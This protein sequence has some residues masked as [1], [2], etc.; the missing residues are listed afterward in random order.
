MM[1]DKYIYLVTPDYML[2]VIEESKGYS[3]SIKAYSNASMAY[4]NLA[5]T[6]QS[7]I[8][9]YLLVYEELPED[10]TDLVILIN[11]INLVGDKDTVVLLAVNDPSGLE[12]T[13][14]PNI[15]TDNIKFMYLKEYEVMTDAVIRRNLFGTI[16]INKFSPYI[17][18]N[19]VPNFVTTFNSN[20]SLVPVLPKDILLILE[21]VQILDT[22]EY[23][24]KHDNVLKNYSD[25][26]LVSYLRLNR[27]Y[28]LFG[29]DVDYEG[30]VS[31]VN[32]SHNI[33]KVLYRVVCGIIRDEIKVE[34]FCEFEDKEVIGV[35]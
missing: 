11:F 26:S 22:V 3:F 6:N 24:I 12:D 34:E 21:P 27:I 7:S 19:E 31:R 20:K 25:N 33:D 15:N 5:Y 1:R 32:S 23:T 29:L 35:G 10:L 17:E 18:N 2:A 14:I 30:M 16:V 8:L 28:A 9:G 4:K 13:L